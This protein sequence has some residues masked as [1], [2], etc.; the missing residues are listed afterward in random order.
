MAERL[1]NEPIVCDVIGLHS[2][3]EQVPSAAD[4]YSLRDLGAVT[5]VCVFCLG[6]AELPRGILFSC[7]S[8][9]R[10]RM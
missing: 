9:G 5:A 6:Q 7:V 4:C 8:V 3:V 1:P 2:R 10:R